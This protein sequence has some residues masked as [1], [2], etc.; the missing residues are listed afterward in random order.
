M[1]L[2]SQVTTWE[3][4][5]LR[6]PA[7]PLGISCL[8]RFS[9]QKE[10]LGD[11]STRTG[12][13]TTRR[14]V[15]GQQR[16]GPHPSRQSC[17]VRTRFSLWRNSLPLPRLQFPTQHLWMLFLSEATPWVTWSSRLNLRSIS[18]FQCLGTS[19]AHLLPQVAQ[20]HV[21]TGSR[22]RVGILL[23]EY[24]LTESHNEKCYFPLNMWF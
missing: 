11:P 19:E 8:F 18:M 10:Y 15:P 5:F 6:S 20:D 16:E 21:H 1:L 4:T 12:T 2:S 24:M 3:V 17:K 13:Q 7:F 9:Q 23:I 22:Q 14:T